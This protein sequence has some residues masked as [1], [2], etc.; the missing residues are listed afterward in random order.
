MRDK[1][2][3]L[4]E[5]LIRWLYRNPFKTLISAFLLLGV[6]V[7]QVPSVTIDTTSEA[8]LHKDDPSLIEYN[9]FRDQFGR[10]EL[11]IIA[12]ESPE[13]FEQSFLNRLKSFHM[14]ALLAVAMF[15][16]LLFCRMSGVILPLLIINAS[17]FSTLGIMALSGVP[18][19]LPTTI[20]PA[21]LLVVG[22][23]DAVHILAI[24][25]RHFDLGETKED[26]RAYAFGHSGLAIV[27]TS[28][29]TISGL[30]SFSLAELSA[31]AEIGYFAAA[32]VMLALI[33]TI[34]M[35]P[36]IIALTPLKQTR[37]KVQKHSFMDRI[38]RSVANFTA[39]RPRMIILFSVGILTISFK[40]CLRMR[41]K[42]P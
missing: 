9:R 19:K 8:L 26:A 31:I 33:Y 12:I 25:F 1:I 2:P 20:I 37:T 39:R 30:L 23:C 34:I 22:V 18:I 36:A 21:F 10:A 3:K 13:V 6:L 40:M 42:P 24:F 4:L 11:I 17:L 14:E 32:G 41:L 16:G 29:T 7:S 15:L 5:S 35:L 27:L 28:L 38:L